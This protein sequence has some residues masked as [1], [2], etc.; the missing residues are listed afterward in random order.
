MFL[1]YVT[2]GQFVVQIC[3][4]W[5]CNIE[6]ILYRQAAENLAKPNLLF[7]ACTM[8]ITKFLKNYLVDVVATEDIFQIIYLLT[9]R[10]SFMVRCKML[11]LFNFTFAASYAT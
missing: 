4:E 9:T 8:P 11:L 5:C 1:K 6:A 3:E 10:I 2:N 7:G